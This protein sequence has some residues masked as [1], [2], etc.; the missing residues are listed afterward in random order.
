VPNYFETKL[1]GGSTKRTIPKSISSVYVGNTLA[2]VQR[3][4]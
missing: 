2:V 3:S 4:G 1:R